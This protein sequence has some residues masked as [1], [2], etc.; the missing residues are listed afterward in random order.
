MSYS[1]ETEEVTAWT[2]EKRIAII[3]ECLALAEAR[4]NQDDLL[5]IKAWR[6]R[7]RE[8]KRTLQQQ[9]ETTPDFSNAEL[10]TQQGT[11]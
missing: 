4:A 6:K 9:R 10:P 8:E 7:L 3:R 1:N 2:P 11:P 5:V